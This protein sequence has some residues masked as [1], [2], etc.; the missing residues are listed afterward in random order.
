MKILCDRDVAA[1]PGLRFYR[2]TSWSGLIAGVVMLGIVVGAAVFL[3]A[4]GALRPVWAILAFL[5]WATVMALPTW[6]FLRTFRASLRDDSWRLAWAPDELYL[7]FRSFQNHRFDPTTPTVVAIPRREVA[8]IR[9]HSQTLETRDDDGD[10]NGRYK[11]KG[12]QIGL[13]P[14]A[15]TAALA[16]ALKEEA[17]RRSP[18]GARFNHYPVTLGTDSIL[19]VEMRRPGPLLKDLRLYYTIA[20]ENAV[21][22]T[23]FEDMTR[24]EKESHIL[25]LVLAG[26]QIDAVK[27]ARDVYGCDLAAAK[28]LVDGLAKS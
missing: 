1:A 9:P 10:W 21:P 23:R 15:N 26:R 24:A 12:I 2:E 14:E 3:Y 19:R 18:R 13:R 25:D 27:A 11:V 6:L 28:T 8:W 17:A 7:R 5:L 20:A 16:D 4:E 22:F